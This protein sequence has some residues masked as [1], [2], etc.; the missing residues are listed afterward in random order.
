LFLGCAGANDEFHLEEADMVDL[1]RAVVALSRPKP[2]IQGRRV[3]PTNTF[4]EFKKENIEQSIPDRFEQQVDRYPNRLAVK[5]KSH[6]LTYDTLNKVTNRVARAILA[7][8]GEGEEPIALLLGHSG[9]A[10]IAILGILKAGKIYVPLDPSYP[11]ARMTYML[12]DSQAGLIVTNNK[13]LS[14]AASLAT[15][16]ATQNVCPVLNINE[17]DTS[18]STENLGLSIP[19]DTNAYL[20][21]TSGSTGQPKGVVHTHRNA[22]HKIRGYTNHCH[23]CA[24]DRLLL[25]ASFSFSSSTATIFGAL[26]NGAAVFPFN[27]KEQ[28]LTRLASWLI[29]EEITIYHSVATS[30]RHFIGT[31]TGEETFPKLRLIRLGS[32]TIYKQDVELYRRHFPQDCILYV[33][34]STTETGSVCRYFVDKETEIADNVVPAG[35]A[36]EGMEILLLD[37]EGQ[38]VGLNQVG[39]IAVRSRCLSPGYWRRPDLTRAKFLPDP[40]GGDKRIYL[41][42][43]LGRMRPDGCL[44]HLG[45]KDFQ[46]KIR[47]YR[48]EVSGIETALHDLDTIK[49]AV[50]VAQDG[51]SGA[52]RLVAYLVP[53]D[54]PAPTVSA[55]R[56]A[57]AETLPDYLI[58]STFV[59]LEKLPLTPNGKVDR[60][61]LPAP[62]TAR[63]ELGGTFVAPRDELELRL[64]RIWE[65]VLGIQPI[66]VR[67]NFFDLGG[68][69]MLAL[70][71]FAQIERITGKSLPVAALFQ[72]P[73]IEQLATILRLEGWV[74]H[75]SSLV[76]IQAGGSRPPFFCLPGSLG[77]VFA[78]LGDLARLL[79]PDQPFYGLQDGIENPSQIKALAAHYVGEIR[80]VQAE[81]PYLLGGL[82]SG[83]VVAFEMAQQLQAQG[84][85]VA[86]LALVEP[87]PPWVPGLRSYSNFVASIFR[88]MVRRFGH[89]SRNVSQLNSAEQRTYARLKMKLIANSWALRRY[90]PQP[91]PGQI[92]LF[93]GSESLRSAHDP[94]LD[95]RKLAIGGA[96]I[97]V[98]LGTHDAITRTHDAIPEETHLQVLA[99]Q[100]RACIDDAVV[101]V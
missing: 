61:A 31:L 2:S 86:L 34:M 66:G 81:G 23:I 68:H 95:W 64:A 52:K 29:Q 56:S 63:P 74:A 72:A 24:D 78:D 80:T 83:G 17:I 25:L 38:T 85:Q 32:E 26:L 20:I 101:G 71:L 84:Q 15:H 19:P 93:L 12:E 42:G 35:H 92:D 50:V 13:N 75:E 27:V 53:S 69:S 11:Q 77:N 58:P 9:S 88:R 76:A 41:T 100:L 54:Q 70:R 22:L 1:S 16:R 44:E 82:C 99:E 73:T 57:L 47:G 90:A 10:I 14:L 43:D 18:L 87:T 37:D 96:E 89:H 49:E 8:R 67:D 3:G 48:V 55:L 6:A 40:E 91:Y 59:M 51:Q 28:G 98:A 36:V 4:I 65:Q 97:H 79:G 62:D 30:F 21:Y 7:Q 39:E 94:R 45:R 5:A 33:G 60:R 46:V